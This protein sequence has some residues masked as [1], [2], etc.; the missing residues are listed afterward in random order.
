MGDQA[1]STILYGHICNLYTDHEALKSLLNT[2]HPSGKLA[3]W[4]LAI[5][6]LDLHIHYRPGRLNQAADVLSHR[7][8]SEE[9]A[10]S[11][12]TAQDGEG[13]VSQVS[14]ENA[15]S[16]A[17]AQDWE[18]MVSRVSEENAT[19][20][21]TAPDEEKMVSQVCTKTVCMS[22]SSCQEQDCDLKRIRDYLLNNELPPDEMKAR[23]IA[24]QK[25]EF[26]VVER[27]LYHVEKDKT[28]RVVPPSQDRRELFELAHGGVFGGHLGSAKV[29]SQLAKH[30]WWSGMRQDIIKWSR[31]CKIC[32][33]R[34]VGTPI[35]TP[36]TPIAVAGPFDRVGIDIIKFPTS[37]K[38][39]KY[40]VVVMDYLTKW[41]EVFP[42][43]DQTSI[44]IARLLVE[45]IVPQ[46]GVPVE[47]LSDRGT[48]FLSKLMEEVYSLLG[49]RKINTTAY[50]P[51]T[52]GLVERF[53]RTLTNM[54]AKKVKKNGKDWDVQL[55][56]HTLNQPHYHFQHTTLVGCAATDAATSLMIY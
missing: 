36:L 7:P 49:I 56:P 33:S 23:E 2:P 1:L 30:Y 8:V 4:G 44:T 15:T 46:H 41:P 28:L 29:H 14:E 10:T 19:S 39:N 27:V 51:Q 45:Q 35:H 50:H 18:G 24:L 48:A 25:S 55:P 22:L 16:V 5:Q 13:M 54:L 21:A 42:T 20:V 43:R 3:Q 6:E 31:A 38:G 37:S 52:D 47:L 11:T 9:N 53:N 12:A 34:Q 32:A 40:A 26:E 17:T